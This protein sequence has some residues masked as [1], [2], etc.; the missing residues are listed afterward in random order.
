M[1]PTERGEKD[2]SIELLARHS[3]TR[4][5][6][7]KLKKC[8]DITDKAV[9]ALAQ[10]CSQLRKVSLACKD[11]ITDASIIALSNVCVTL[12][13]LEL[14]ECNLVTDAVLQA[15]ACRHGATLKDL[16]FY[17]SREVTDV[18]VLALALHCP[19]LTRIDL[20]GRKRN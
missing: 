2:E 18:G 14:D 8:T 19:H 13:D 15:V 20:V 3:G 11:K 10:H 9:F 7:L 12:E 5:K 1:S 6:T 17:G 4:L 16:S